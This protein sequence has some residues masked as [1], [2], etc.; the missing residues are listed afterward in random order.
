M[1]KSNMTHYNFE[2]SQK[3]YFN[4]PS[5]NN[6]FGWIIVYH[7]LS[8]VIKKSA[9]TVSLDSLWAVFNECIFNFPFKEVITIFGIQ[10]L[11]VHHGI[12]A[13]RHIP[14][15]PSTILVLRR[16]HVLIHVGVFLRQLSRIGQILTLITQRR[17]IQDQQIRRRE[18]QHTRCST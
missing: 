8:W 18:E 15:D 11:R 9:I 6:N 14:L 3:Y 2:T 10:R 5:S 17:I 4:F 13:L 16:A 12:F 7:K 1:P